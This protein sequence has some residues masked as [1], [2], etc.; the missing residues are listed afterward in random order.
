MKLDGVGSVSG[1][2]GWSGLQERFGGVADS[3]DGVGVRGREELGAGFG[4]VDNHLAAGGSVVEQGAEGGGEVGGSKAG[5]EE[6]RDDAAGGGEGGDRDREGTVGV[7]HGGDFGGVADH[8]FDD[9]EGERGDAVD[10]DE[11]IADGEGL[12]GGGSAGDDGG[13]GVVEG[14]AG[15]SH[16]GHTGRIVF[17][18]IQDRK[19]TRLNSS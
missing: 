19:S 13:A 6:F 12:D 8:A 2:V 14:F 17:G 7:D 10:D 16:K 15:V 1:Y 11:G 18:E 5:V 9:G 4:E 3:V